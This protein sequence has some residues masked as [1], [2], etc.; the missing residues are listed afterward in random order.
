MQPEVTIK[1]DNQTGRWVLP[2]RAIFGPAGSGW[3]AVGSM[4]RGVD[5]FCAKTGACLHVCTSD[6]QTAIP[7]RLCV[8]HGI[9]AAAT[10]SGRVH[11]WR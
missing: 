11:L 6:F 4:K 9:V 7:A 5:F 3:V 8:G 1:H 2:F 10:S